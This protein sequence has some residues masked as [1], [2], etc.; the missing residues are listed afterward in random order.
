M[1]VMTGQTKRRWMVAAVGAAVGG[2]LVLLMFRQP[3][4]PRVESLASAKSSPARAVTIIPPKDFAVND[5][6]TLL[7][8]T[9]LFLPTKWN[10]TQREIAPPEPGGRFQGYDVPRWSFAENDLKLGL[11]DP[12]KTPANPVEAVTSERP[13]VVLAGFGRTDAAVGPPP[14]RGAMVEVVAASTGKKVLTHVVT[15]APPGKGGWQPMEFLAG[16]DAAGLVGPLAV[17]TRSGEEEVDAYFVNYLS[18]RLR[19]GERLAPGF[20]R[21]SVGP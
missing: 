1:V 3:T 17:T 15:E 18:R 4:A 19:V 8:P 13:T 6:A 5:E 21:I 14:A 16:V 20:Y 7:D 2:A 10:A 12:I 11:P 9:P